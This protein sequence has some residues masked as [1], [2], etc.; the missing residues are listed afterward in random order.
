MGPGRRLGGRGSVDCQ[1][2]IPMRAFFRFLPVVL[3]L[4]GCAGGPVTP[5]PQP[6][7]DREAAYRAMESGEY[8][9]A[10][11][12]FERLAAASASPEREEFQLQAARAML[13]AGLEGQAAQLLAAVDRTA[14]RPDL[15]MQH[16]LLSAALRL[17]T[18][19]DQAL[20]LLLEPAA[21]EQETELH[22]RYHHLRARAFAQLGNHL[23]AAREYIERELFLTDR[24]AI[25]ANQLAIWEAL[26]HLSNQA[27]EQLRIHPPPNVLSGWMELA[28]IAKNID[29]PTAH[30]AKQLA[31]W[32]K[33]YR[34]HPALSSF[35]DALEA[36]SQA[37]VTQPGQIAVLLPLTGP[38]AQAADAVRDGI[39]AAYYASPNRGSVTLRFYDE[40]SALQVANRYR[41][42]VADGAEFVI[43]PLD[44]EAVRMLAR[45]TDLPVPTIA[46]NYAEPAVSEALYQFSLAP[47]A[48]A[49]QVAELAWLD[50]HDNAALL[51]PAGPWGDR[52]RVSFADRWQELGGQVV[53]RVEYDPEQNDFSGPLKRMLNLDESERRRI[54]V[55]DVIGRQVE[56]EARRRG[57]IDF[58]FLAAFPRQA[59][60][61]RPQL[62]FHRAIGVPVY[63]TSHLYAGHHD[64]AQD[65][66][67]D[68]VVFGD[69]P[70]TLETETPYAETRR[71]SKPLLTDHSGS[72]QRLVALGFDAFHLVPRLKLLDSYPNDRFQGETGR[73][74][75]D[76]VNRVRR[77]LI[78][79]QFRGGIPTVLTQEA[80]ARAETAEQ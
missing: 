35:L 48:E 62:R 58:V 79:A 54:A 14:L 61:L 51:I 71:G 72:L 13:Q 60:L 19:P 70:W 74:H 4:A 45:E 57:D 32:R 40:G 10:A 36:K 38:F 41:A 39:L 78:W 43:G 63:G 65:R 34:G 27:L 3:L 2:Y 44:K 29:Q 15:A 55:Q 20:T 50:G 12:R 56:F 33:N 22:A 25:E 1:L 8:H 17:P 76:P 6:A 68:G 69:M 52:V 66:D 31:E 64:P 80:V 16:Q 18:A 75:V 42:A 7:S 30:L 59:R 23:E 67:M 46:L 5:K 37:L 11:R 28:R 49:R 21:P 77:Q 47:E 73:L 24:D 9:A 53:S 26:S